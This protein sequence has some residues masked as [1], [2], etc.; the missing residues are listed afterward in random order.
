M[1]NSFDNDLF[2]SDLR[3]LPKD[4]FTRV[5]DAF[6]SIVKKL[7]G[8]FVV[9]ILKIQLINSAAKLLNISDVFGFFQIECEETDEIKARSC[10]KDKNGHLIVKPGIRTGVLYLVK[11]LKHKLQQER[12]LLANDGDEFED[13]FM[14]SALPENH[15]LLRSLMKWY[16][17]KDQH[18]SDSKRFLTLFIDN[19]VENLPR[20]PNSFKYS[21][22][23]KDF[24][25]CLYVLGGKQTY[26][27]VRLNLYGSIPNLST[28]KSLI[29]QSELTNNEG[30][31]K[32]DLLKNKTKQYGFC[33]E[34]MT[35]VVPKIEYNTSTDSFV[36][37]VSPLINGLPSP[38]AYPAKTL[39]ELKITF[40]NEEI[41][42]LINIHM[43]QCLPTDD[44]TSG[45]S[46][47]FLLSAY[48]ANSKFTSVDIIHRWF[49]IFRHCLARDVRL[50]GFSTGKP[51]LFDDHRDADLF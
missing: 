30:E 39:D 21:K 14:D 4:I 35:G 45:I 44:N 23:V 11:L 41:A 43:M 18:E 5:D 10:F 24:A 6:F 50:I 49:Y 2:A 13:Y 32:F 25:L 40:E 22:S 28:I 42:S 51:I 7:V 37:F 36:G 15:P 12:D 34:D 19:L 27:F 3:L 8:D 48:G 47:P 38:R 26:E 46:K 16:R 20:F 17:I 1:M 31:F 9:D 33:S 29:S